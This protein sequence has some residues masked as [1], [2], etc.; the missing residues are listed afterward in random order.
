MDN[1]YSIAKKIIDKDEIKMERIDKN[2]YILRFSISSDKLYIK[3]LIG[4]DIAKILYEV[5]KDIFDEFD[6][7]LNKNGDE[8]EVYFLIKHFFSD[9][10]LP[11]KYMH[12]QIQKIQDEKS[13]AILFFCQNANPDLYTSVLNIPSKGEQMNTD[14]IHI[15]CNAIND[16][17]VDVVNTI[18][19]NNHV[20]IP[21]VVEKMAGILISKMFLKVK[22]FI[23]TAPTL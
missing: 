20:D 15:V 12:L 10:G 6:M 18:F 13:D 7:N 11:Q 4:F 23:E 9:F 19:L 5:N 1:D 16:H 8:A 21:A 17:K 3:K 2:K 14:L 22:Q